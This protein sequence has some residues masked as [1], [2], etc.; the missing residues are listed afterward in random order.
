M[1]NGIE[2]WNVAIQK[3]KDW[4]EISWMEP[5]QEWLEC[6]LEHLEMVLKATDMSPVFVPTVREEWVKA[7]E[8]KPST[9]LEDPENPPKQPNKPTG[10]KPARKHVTKKSGAG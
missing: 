5:E 4:A 8:L 2:K 3:E 10:L 1:K 7:V 6:W 9:P